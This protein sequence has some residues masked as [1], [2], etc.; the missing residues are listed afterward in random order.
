[1]ISFPKAKAWFMVFRVL[2]VLVWAVVATIFGA[3]ISALE[4]DG[5]N[6]TNLLL[7]MGMTALIQGFPTHIINEIYDW[8][9]GADQ[10]R[11]LREKS[12]G[13]KVIKAGLTDIDGLWVMFTV[14]MI[15]IFLSAAYAVLVIGW[16]VLWFIVPGFL[17]GLFYT[18]PPFR[19]AY[20][21]FAGEW[22]GGFAGIFFAV[23]GS[24]Y[25]QAFRIGRT[26]ILGA[27]CLGLIY[28]GIMM[29]FHYLD[30]EGDRRAHPQKRTT[31]VLLGLQ[32]SKYYVYTCLLAALALALYCAFTIHWVFILLALH[33]SI[34]LVFQIGCNPQDSASI[35]GY[36]RLITYETIA[37]GLIFAVVIRLEFLLL[38]IPIFFGFYA[39]KKF[40]K[41]WKN[42]T[43]LS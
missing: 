23:T 29:L 12:G 32:R 20:L 2:P 37:W 11:K 14:T 4:T 22:L 16:Q 27:F 19:L 31:I 8:K 9:S 30:Y 40:G 3:A 21:P 13:S 7:V 10:F 39:H 43:S 1:M 24:Y 17:C 34:H 38:F 26:I 28:I 15:V 6:W 36:G 35:V 25:V 18:L 41:V 5:I 33:T 42:M